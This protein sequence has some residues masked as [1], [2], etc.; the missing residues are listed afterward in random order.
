MFMALALVKIIQMTFMFAFGIM[1][2]LDLRLHQAFGTVMRTLGI[3]VT[4][5]AGYGSFNMWLGFKG[6]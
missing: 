5:I 3:F 6:R 2:A 1:T 4:L